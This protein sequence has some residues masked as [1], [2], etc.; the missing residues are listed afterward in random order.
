MKHFWKLCIAVLAAT[1]SV[2]GVG[3]SANAQGTTPLS[4]TQQVDQNGQ[5]L[6]GCLLYS[7]IAGTV[8]TPQQTY[9]DPSLTQAQ[10]NPLTCDVTGRV[11]L[12][13]YPSGYTHIRLT[14]ASG[15]VKVDQTLP[16]LGI[17]VATSGGSGGTTVDPTTILATGDVKY[18]F[19]AEILTGFVRLNG[20]TIGSASSGASERANAD[21]QNLFVYLWTNCATP[22]SNNHCAVS[23]GLGATALADFQAN[24]Q[25]TLPDMRDAA[26][27]GRDCMGNT[28]LGGLL[29]SNILSGHGDGVD[30]AAAWGGLANQTASTTIAQTNLP[31]VNFNVSGISLSSLSPPAVCDVSPCASLGSLAFL[32]SNA[33]NTSFWPSA[34]SFTPTI[35]INNTGG[36]QGVAASGGSGAAAVST[37]FPIMNPFKLGTFY[38]KL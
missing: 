24:K 29:S 15:N 37:T 13:W 25:I 12:A 2:V 19:T 38:M 7:Y 1:V 27:V 36:V 16:V 8:A 34:S 30:T 33:T 4:L 22:S 6:S 10:S 32:L 5:P 17:A 14:D 9:Q 3:Q 26:L 11:P 35:T 18:R 20:N 31:N 28:C 23:G 21:T